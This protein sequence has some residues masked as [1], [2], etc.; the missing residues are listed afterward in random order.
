MI[1]CFLVILSFASSNFFLPRFTRA[2]QSI[3]LIDITLHNP[4]FNCDHHIFIVTFHALKE[5][6][7]SKIKTYISLMRQKSIF[8]SHTCLV[9]LRDPVITASSSMMANLLCI[10]NPFL[11]NRTGIPGNDTIKIRFT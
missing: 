1:T 5:R 9:Q 2:K 4:R 11:F 7:N 10:I 3:K 8:H 6:T